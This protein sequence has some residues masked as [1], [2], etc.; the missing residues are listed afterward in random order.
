EL[1]CERPHARDE[2]EWQQKSLAQAGGTLDRLL[3]RPLAG[4]VVHR[5]RQLDLDL[6]VEVAGRPALGV[7]Q[8]KPA[9]PDLRPVL[10]LRRNLELDA[11]TLEGWRR[12]L[13]AVERDVQR[14][15]HDDAQVLA[16][17]DEQRV[18]RHL[19]LRA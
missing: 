7:R 6:R 9:Q 5:H 16:L 17:S 12:Y 14:H 3:R 19:D 13:A 15:R 11:T 2:D 10:G 1:D 8:P 4:A 18:W